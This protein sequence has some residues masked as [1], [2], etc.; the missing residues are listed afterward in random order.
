[1]TSKNNK[2]K[3]TEE[4]LIGNLL[5]TCKKFGIVHFEDRIRLAFSL[6]GSSSAVCPLFDENSYIQLRIASKTGKEQLNWRIETLDNA[7]DKKHLPQPWTHPSLK[8]LQF[9]ESKRKAG[10]LIANLFQKL[11]T[12]STAVDFDVQFGLTK[13]WHF[14]RCTLKDLLSISELPP[15][16][17]LYVPFFETYFLEAVYCTGVDYQVERISFLSFFLSLFRFVF[18]QLTKPISFHLE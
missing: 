5:E 6:F 15:S 11:P 10:Y 14:G 4:R 9:Y 1:M 18:L 16:V 12:C 2:Y 3:E 17:R 7:G 13:L 8:S